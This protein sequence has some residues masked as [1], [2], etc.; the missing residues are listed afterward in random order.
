MGGR[1]NGAGRE[2][3]REYCTILLGPNRKS[4]RKE[5]DWTCHYPLSSAMLK[6]A[7]GAEISPPVHLHFMN[8]P[9]QPDE[10][11]GRGI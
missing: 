8:A 11:K 7:V 4:A 1:G 9:Q 5:R 6:H 10:K 2:R 3:E